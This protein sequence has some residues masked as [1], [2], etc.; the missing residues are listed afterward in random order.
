MRDFKRQGFHLFHSDEL[1][2]Q[3]LRIEMFISDIMTLHLKLLSCVVEF[4]MFVVQCCVF[5]SLLDFR[6]IHQQELVV[7]HLKII[8]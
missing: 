1:L 4:F 8:L 6:K 7:L 3:V 2:M 5:A